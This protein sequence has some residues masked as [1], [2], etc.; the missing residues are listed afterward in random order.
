MIDYILIKL[1]ESIIRSVQPII[2][3][4]KWV[5]MTRI[6]I[7]PTEFVDFLYSMPPV[8]IKSPTTEVNIF[9]LHFPMGTAEYTPSYPEYG[10]TTY[11]NRVEVVYADE[12][13]YL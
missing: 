13:E 12:I 1:S 8:K 10:I 2:S 3:G 7:S 9:E 11:H 6:T 5:F 4:H